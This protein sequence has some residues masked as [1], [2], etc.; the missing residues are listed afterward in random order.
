MNS[1]W[2]KLFTE[3]KKKESLFSS[4]ISFP[5]QVEPL[6]L[7]IY[8]KNEIWLCVAFRK[9]LKCHRAALS[10][11]LSGG[12]G[13]VS[14][15][16][17]SPTLLH[18]L[19]LVLSVNCAPLPSVPLWLEAHQWSGGRETNELCPCKCFFFAMHVR[20]TFSQHRQIHAGVT[21]DAPL[22]T[23]ASYRYRALVF[24]VPIPQHR[25]QLYLCVVDA[26]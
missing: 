8:D 14:P 24:H 15:P 18:L 1:K 7:D 23:N 11:V 3:W 20:R 19:A 17:H 26:T 10:E 6:T 5:S 4:L 13:V 9:A 2:N 22:L 21:M 16:L 25:Y 12:G